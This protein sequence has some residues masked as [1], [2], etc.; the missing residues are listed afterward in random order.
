MN[1]ENFMPV[2]LITFPEACQLLRFSRTTLW[3]RIQT[4]PS[5][6]RPIL[7]GA[8]SPRLSLQEIERYLTQSRDC[9]IPRG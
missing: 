2:Q 6:P 1:A 3:R 5:F 9:S 8:R 7:V 4:D